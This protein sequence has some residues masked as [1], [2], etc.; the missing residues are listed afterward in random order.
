MK[1]TKNAR[2]RIKAE[3]CVICVLALALVTVLLWR[4]GR[5]KETAKEAAEA[6]PV[7]TA[8]PTSVPTPSPIPPDMFEWREGEYVHVEYGPSSSNTIDASRLKNPG[9]KN[10]EDLVAWAQMAWENQWGYVWGTFG[11]VLTEDLLQYKLDQYGEAVEEYEQIIREKWMGR[12]VVDCAGLIKAYGWYEPSE[13][14]IMYCSS[15]MPDIG[16]DGFYEDAPDKG[17]IDTLPETP[18]LLVYAPGHIGVYI[19]DGWAIEAISHAGGV[20]K[21]RVADRTWTHW[22]QCPYIQY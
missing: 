21:T 4:S 3:L 17:P 7:P 10:S 19:G 8:I 5:A 12:R 15:D 16:T 2:G 14:A 22:L 1:K 20:V 13:D 11:D 9:V 18:G 6:T